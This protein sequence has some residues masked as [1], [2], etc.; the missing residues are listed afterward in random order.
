MFAIRLIVSILILAAGQS[1]LLRAVA[2]DTVSREERARLDTEMAE[3]PAALRAR[4]DQSYREWRKT[5]ERSDILVSSNAKAVRSSEE[6]RSLVS[7]GPRILPLVVDKLLQP[8]EFFAL[9]IYDVL[10]DRPELRDEHS[11]AGEQQRALATA[12]RW[13]S[14]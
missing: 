10:Q 9:Q 7:L 3:L 13:L 4:F 2:A 14:R 1:S 5:W 12:H 8:E 11:E 6:F